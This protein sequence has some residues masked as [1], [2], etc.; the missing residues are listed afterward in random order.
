M[1]ELRTYIFAIGFA[2]IYIIHKISD[3]ITRRTY[4]AT[5]VLVLALPPRVKKKPSILAD[6]YVILD[7]KFTLF[8]RALESVNLNSGI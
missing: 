5:K 6:F 8:A 1:H 7:Q 3:R 4:G 2:I